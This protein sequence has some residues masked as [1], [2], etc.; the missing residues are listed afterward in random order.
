VDWLPLA[1][2]LASLQLTKS[3]PTQET[4]QVNKRTVNRYTGSYR[5]NIWNEQ[6]GAG[7]S[8]NL[9]SDSETQTST[10]SAVLRGS[11]FYTSLVRDKFAHNLNSSADVQAQSADIEG[12]NSLISVDSVAS[13]TRFVFRLTNPRVNRKVEHMVFGNYNRYVADLLSRA[14]SDPKTCIFASAAALDRALRFLSIHNELLDAANLVY[15]HGRRMQLVQNITTFNIRLQCALK[16]KITHLANT[17][18]REMAEIGVQPNSHT[19]ALVYAAVET[20]DARAEVLKLIERCNPP[21]STTSWSHLALTMFE[22]QLKLASDKELNLLASIKEL[23][24]TFGRDWMFPKTL[25][26]G[27]HI[28]KQRNLD[29]VAKLL[30]EVAERRGIQMTKDIHVYHFALARRQKSTKRAVDRLCSMIRK[31]E[32]PMLSLVI[33]RVFMTAWSQKC[34]NTCRV[35]WAFAATRGLITQTMQTVVY[36]ALLSN[37]KTNPKAESPSKSQVARLAWQ[38]LASKLIVG[39]DFDSARFLEH[40]P[41]LAAYFG[42][43]ASTIQ[44]VSTWTPDDG[45]RDEQISLDYTTLHRD[46]EAWQYRR[47]MAIKVLSELL[48]EAYQM[49]LAWLRS[50]KLNNATAVELD[51]QAI[52]IKRHLN[53]DWLGY[54]TRLSRVREDLIRDAEAFGLETK[55]D[56]NHSWGYRK[57]E[58]DQ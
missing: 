41:L 20:L 46:L 38:R 17:T 36:R 54:N 52:D 42:H 21:M 9:H 56:G 50:G 28:C 25:A 16:R 6:A 4:V 31:D 18:V 40:F 53:G 37:T 27:L 26:R 7:V 57:Y 1:K 33:P 49:D 3:S 58:S 48:T 23:D 14:F 22:E 19:W 34:T 44:M 8:V 32:E 10:R 24:E 11:P 5:P 15:A 55:E 51:P 30:F 35:L 45:T 43:S 13:F 2:T 12:Q 47:P 39:I 29:K